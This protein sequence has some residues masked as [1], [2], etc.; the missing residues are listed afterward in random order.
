MSELVLQ[1]ALEAHI[2]LR[3]WIKAVPQ[4]TP[5][6][7]MPGVDGDWLDE[8]EHK[9]RKALTQQVEPVRHDILEKLTYHRYE[10][11]DMT[12]DDCLSYLQTGGW[13]KVSGRS[14]REL[15][16]QLTEL[17]AA[18][19]VVKLQSSLPITYTE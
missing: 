17:L 12:L 6:P 3:E 8:V 5:L 18:A 7:T 16:L 11:H 9:L 4:D 13:H 2:A 10:R 14:E 15:V 19:P 1:Q